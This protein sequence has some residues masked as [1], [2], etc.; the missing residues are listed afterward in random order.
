MTSPGVEVVNGEVTSGGQSS[1]WRDD[2]IPYTLPRGQNVPATLLL[3][4]AI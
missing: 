1:W 4:W 3:R 2:W